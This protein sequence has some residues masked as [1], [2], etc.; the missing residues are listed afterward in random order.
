MTDPIVTPTDAPDADV[1]APE[2]E[3]VEVGAFMDERPDEP[4][5]DP[6]PDD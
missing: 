3:D 6:D 2:E 1:P 4:V 5:E